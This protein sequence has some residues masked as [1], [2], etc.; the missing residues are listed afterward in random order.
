M[1]VCDCVLGLDRL[2]FRSFCLFRPSTPAL[3]CLSFMKGA[4]GLPRHLSFSCMCAARVHV[5]PAV[6]VVLLSLRLVPSWHRV[7][8][9]VL[10]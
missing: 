10:V 2:R 7:Q 1:R 3:R 4:G 8:C 9:D 6:G 5:A